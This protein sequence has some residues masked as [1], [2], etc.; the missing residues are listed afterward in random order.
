M[1]RVTDWEIARSETWK[2]CPNEHQRA[3]GKCEDLCKLENQ[4]KPM[5]REAKNSLYNMLPIKKLTA[6]M[7]L[8]G[9]VTDG[10]S[11]D[12]E[13]CAVSQAH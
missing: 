10:Q 3:T 4:R 2:K 6:T 12:S 8:V 11:Q 13:D 9:A 1:K 5:M 7:S